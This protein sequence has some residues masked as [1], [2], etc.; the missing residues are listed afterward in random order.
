M[1]AA[2]IEDLDSD[3]F[4]FTSWLFHEPS[5]AFYRQNIKDL[6]GYD[7]CSRCGVWVISQ[8]IASNPTPCGCIYT[9]KCPNCGA[10]D[11]Y[12]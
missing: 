6:N 3:V 7:K 12:Y 10:T 2:S 5:L 4:I 1:L 9:Y 11:T 8:L